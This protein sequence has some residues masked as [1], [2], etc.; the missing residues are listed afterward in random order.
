MERN[1]LRRRLR[2]IVRLKLLPATEGIDI[3]VRS[4]P[5]TYD[6][7]FQQLM[8]EIETIALKLR[9]GGSDE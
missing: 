9:T 7:T 8:T 2:E 6:A 1:L 4:F 3:V 5:A